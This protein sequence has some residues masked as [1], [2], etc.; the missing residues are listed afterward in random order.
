MVFSR[1]LW[2]VEVGVLSLPLVSSIRNRMPINSHMDIHHINHIRS[3]TDSQI[4]VISIMLVN[5]NMPRKSLDLQLTKVNVDV[6]KE[7]H[8][9]QGWPSFRRQ[10]Y[11]IEATDSLRLVFDIFIQMLLQ[12]KKK[13]HLEP[14]PKPIPNLVH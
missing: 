11:S 4:H 5:M 13:R 10:L 14:T 12:K 3:D 6:P 1:L 9:F 8:P 7:T 2:V